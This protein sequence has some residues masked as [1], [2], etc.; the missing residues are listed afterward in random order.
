MT[1]DQTNV[2]ITDQTLTRAA[3]KRATRSGKAALQ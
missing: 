2:A 3:L 1:V